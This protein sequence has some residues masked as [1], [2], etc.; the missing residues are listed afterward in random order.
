MQSFSL[1]QLARIAFL[2]SAIGA[3]AC[4]G[5]SSGSRRYRGSSVL[6]T[7]PLSTKGNI[8]IVSGAGAV[9]VDTAGDSGQLAVAA[10]PFAFAAGDAA[11]EREALSM[12]NAAPSLVLSPDG[13]GVTANQPG[14][15][16]VGADLTVHLPN[17][18]HGLLSV[19]AHFGN[20]TYWASPSAPGA[21]FRVGVGDVDV[22]NA[23]NQLNIQADDG[24]I[25]V[26]A[27]ATLAGPDTQGNPTPPSS[28]ITAR[29]NIIA[30]IPDATSL[31]IDA[32]IGSGGTIRPQ[33]D[34]DAVMS[35]D[36]THA[37]ISVGD[38]TSGVLTVSSGDGDITFLRP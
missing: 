21:S 11:G 22:E 24:D 8:T 25:L 35:E 30:K 19:Q 23:G 6:Q 5:E 13:S 10:V 26:V 17:P 29:G 1:I 27:A 28:I 16:E 14:D 2:G 4:S 32:S 36:G 3:L 37:L 20:V 15:G 31:S 34:Q 18:F 9:F 33:A 12:M 38:G 7:I